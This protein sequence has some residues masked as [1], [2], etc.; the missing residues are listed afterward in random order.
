MKSMHLAALSVIFCVGCSLP[1]HDGE[2]T[3]ERRVQ[4]ICE[5][6]EEVEMRFFRLQGVGVLVRNKIPMELQQ[7]PAAAG[8]FYSNGPNSVRGKGSELLLEV[9][10]MVP[11]KC[12]AERQNCRRGDAV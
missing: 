12:H 6:G 4:Y 11:I 5:N 7:Q 3:G 2:P 10:R 1:A 8:F 9:G